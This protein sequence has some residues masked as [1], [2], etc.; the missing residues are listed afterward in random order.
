MNKRET[1][2][3]TAVTGVSFGGPLFNEFH[4]YVEEK[5]EGPIL[6]LEMTAQGFWDKLKELAMDDFACLVENVTDE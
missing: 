5:F 3:I 2:I 4:K 1:A 6:T